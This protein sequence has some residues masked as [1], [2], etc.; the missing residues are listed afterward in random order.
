MKVPRNQEKILW[1][2]LTYI[3]LFR[4]LTKCQTISRWIPPNLQKKNLSVSR[5]GMAK[6]TKLVKP[7][8][9]D[10]LAQLRRM[11]LLPAPKKR[12]TSPVGIVPWLAE[13]DWNKDGHGTKMGVSKNRRTPK[14]SILPV[15]PHKVVAEV[16]RIGNY[17]RDW[18][19]WV[20]D[21]RAKTLMDP[22]VQVSRWLIVEL[23]NWL[24][25]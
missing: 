1:Y 11:L 20:T 18:L 24:I 2:Q 14:S 3:N 4:N 16:S 5:Q 10:C 6:N 9:G 19:L 23:T 15:V 17:G 22:T 21:G 13:A 7:A 25:D 8:I 12:V